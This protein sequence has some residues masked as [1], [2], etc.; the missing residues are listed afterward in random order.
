MPG[1]TND[2]KRDAKASMT[3]ETPRR[4][5]QAGDLEEFSVYPD[6][7][8]ELRSVLRKNTWAANFLSFYFL[9]TIIYGIYQHRLQSILI[10][11]PLLFLVLYVRNR[12]RAIVYIGADGVAIEGSKGI[13]F[14]ERSQIKRIWFQRGRYANNNHPFCIVFILHKR[15]W[16]IHKRIIAFNDPNYPYMEYCKKLAPT[17]GQNVPNPDYGD[18]YE[19]FTAWLQRL[20]NGNN[21]P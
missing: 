14:I 13:R 6:E 16:K 15:M 8:P 4:E 5:Q 9:A 10:A 17:A 20:L 1:L 7:T 2:L 18:G 3:T 19:K 11:F 21:K 12:M